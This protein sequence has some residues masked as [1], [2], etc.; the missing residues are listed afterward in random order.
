M[1]F[2]QTLFALAKRVQWCW[3]NSVGE[4]NFVVMFCGLHIKMTLWKTIGE[5]LEGSGWVPILTEAGCA[6]TATVDS[7][8]KCAHLTKTRHA[9]QVTAMA[10]AL[11]QRKALESFKSEEVD[12]SFG[13]WRQDSIEKSPTF[14]FWDMILEFEI[15]FS[16]IHSCS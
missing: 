16:H 15:H 4:D 12:K 7:F 2:D 1:A 13:E 6:S 8:L 3:P 14:Q 11:L 9:H 10:L 5:L